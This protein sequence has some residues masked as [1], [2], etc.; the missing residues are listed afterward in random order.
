MRNKLF[1][2]QKL[3]AMRHDVERLAIGFDVSLEQ[4]RHRLSTL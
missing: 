3:R 1:I 4:V 2:G